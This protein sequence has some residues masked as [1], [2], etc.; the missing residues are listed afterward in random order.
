MPKLVLPSLKYKKSFLEDF[1]KQSEMQ[2]EYVLTG[3]AKKAVKNNFPNFIK[4]LKLQS[5]GVFS[6]TGK[7]PQTVFWLVEKNKFIGKLSIRH[8][9]TP[10][11]RKI[12]GHIGYYIRHEQRGK[13]YGKLILKLGLKK[14]KLLDIKNVLVTCDASNIK[15]KKVIEGNGGKFAGK[16]KQGKKL[17]DKLKYWLATK[18]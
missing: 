1:L 4:K 14:A 15:S 5:K 6:Q 18:F 2:D 17:P 7:V 10:Y 13:G 12:G 3:I 9:L 16:I 8:K 11:L